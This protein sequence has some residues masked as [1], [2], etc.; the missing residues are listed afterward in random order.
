MTFRQLLIAP[1]VVACLVSA[2]AQAYPSLQ[3]DILGGTYDSSTETIVASHNSFSV[4]A[5]LIPDTKTALLSDTYYL[6][7]ALI[8]ATSTPGN[9]GSFTV[10]STP[11]NVTGSMTYG[12][13][14]LDTILA[15]A[16]FD[17]GDLPKHDVFP[18]YFYQEAFKFTTTPLQSAKYDT[19]LHAGWGPQAGTGMY[20]AKFDI[21]V[22][23]MQAGKGIHFDLY[24]EKLVQK[25]SKSNCTATDI[26]VNQFAPFSHDAEGMVTTVPEPETYAML[27]A[28]LGLMGFVARRRRKA[29]GF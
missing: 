2:P 11:M 4:Y 18:T 16:G 9:Y 19:A 5:Y 1:A 12:T 6:S 7:M 8:P 14:P 13:P 17:P 26:D 3:L 23:G 10:N 15:G 22:S 25:C 28:G 29:S 21:N 27:L 24:N 20:Y